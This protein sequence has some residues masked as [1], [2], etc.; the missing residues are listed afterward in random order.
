MLGHGVFLSASGGNAKNYVDDSI[1]VLGLTVNGENISKAEFSDAVQK[2]ATE[3][4]GGS[5]TSAAL[6]YRVLVT[7]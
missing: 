7:P 1:L 4:G 5:I 3:K 2:A 6:V